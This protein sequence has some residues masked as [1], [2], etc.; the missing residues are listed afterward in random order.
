MTHDHVM[1]LIWG[2]GGVG[3]LVDIVLGAM[4][5]RAYR[6]TSALIDMIHECRNGQGQPWTAQERGLSNGT[7]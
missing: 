3:L 1:I 6:E 4:A 7:D 2:V 5:W